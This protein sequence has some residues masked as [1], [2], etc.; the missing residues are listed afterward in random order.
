MREGER[1]IA[2]RLLGVACVAAGLLCAAVNLLQAHYLGQYYTGLFPIAGGA[3]GLGVALLATNASTADLRDRSKP[4]PARVTFGAM[5]LGAVAG[6]A[7]N[8][9]FH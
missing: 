6:L 5:L 2:P 7:A 8:T 9:I 3:I 4:G 1:E